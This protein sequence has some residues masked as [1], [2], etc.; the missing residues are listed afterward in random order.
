MGEKYIYIYAPLCILFVARCKSHICMCAF[1][2]E[3]RALDRLKPREAKEPKE[4]LM[5]EH[6]HFLVSIKEDEAALAALEEKIKSN[7][8][9]NDVIKNKLL[10]MYEYKVPDSSAVHPTVV[11][12][13]TTVTNAAGDGD[14]GGESGET[15]PPSM[16]AAAEVKKK[17]S[18]R[19]LLKLADKKQKLKDD[20]SK[21][22]FLVWHETKCC[23]F[24]FPPFFLVR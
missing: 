2:Q 11:P 18:R 17:Y 8:L 13:T 16:E 3:E 24:L 5:A 4:Q 7:K 10:V 20:E 9:K 22:F 15:P 19:R 12:S 14:G 21:V 1:V 6:E 23:V